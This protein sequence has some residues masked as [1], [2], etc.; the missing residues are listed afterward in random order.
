MNEIYEYDCREAAADSLD[1]IADTVNISVWTLESGDF[2]R[3]MKKVQR[4][5]KTL[6]VILCSWRM[7]EAKRKAEAEQ[8]TIMEETTTETTNQNQNA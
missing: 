2:E 5:L 6:N 8:A 1:R 7:L 3:R 4:E